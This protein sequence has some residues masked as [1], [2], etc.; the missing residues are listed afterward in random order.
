[1]S[2]M[3]F[4]RACAVILLTT[5]A[6]YAH[7][8]QMQITATD[9][10][11]VTREILTDTY[12]PLATAKSV[13]VMEVLDFRGVWYTRPETV[14]N[15]PSHPTSPGQP[16]YYSGPGLAFGVGQTFGVGSVLSVNFTSGLQL[17]NGT[18]FGDA[19]SAE[20]QY[21]RGGS[22]G[23]SGQL[24][25]P[26][27]SITTTDGG[28]SSAL[29]FAAIASGFTESA[30]SSARFRFLGD[31]TTTVV[32]TG[33]IAS[34][35]ADGVYLASLVL[36]SDDPAV[37]DSDPFYFVMHKGVPW[38]DVAAAVGSLNVPNSA[39]QVLGVPEPTTLLM[40]SL[41]MFGLFAR[42]RHRVRRGIW[43]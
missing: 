33:N 25:T 10:K 40:V 35:P 4:V 27:A 26:T 8:P 24:N 43:A 37:A 14:L 39:V 32:G 16:T 15:P 12:T 42:R 19:G 41:G 28:A 31:G 17:W 11:I 7:G 34:E 3:N 21:Y 30:H 29:A 23:T 5:S 9:G 18:S 22:I 13:Y 6:A 1:M 36:A 20:L 2:L 38:S